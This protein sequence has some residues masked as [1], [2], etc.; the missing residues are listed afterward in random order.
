MMRVAVTDIGSNSTRLLVADVDDDGHVTELE[1]RTQV[2]RLGEGVDATGRLADAAIARVLEALDGYAAVIER[3]GAQA[4]P[5]VLTSAV[6]DAANGPEFVAAVERRYG[7]EARAISAAISA[8]NA[9]SSG[10]VGGSDH[11]YRS[12]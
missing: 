2:T 8:P 5:A 11:R 4:R 3:C 12:L 10:Q 1:R 7:L 9:S 6:R